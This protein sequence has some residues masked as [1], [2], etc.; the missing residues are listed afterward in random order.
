[1]KYFI[2][3][4]FHEYMKQPK[5]LGI[6]PIGKV[7]PTV[8][9]ISLALVSE[10]GSKE[11]YAETNWYNKR[12]ARKNAFLNKNVIPNLLGGE[13]IKSKKEI[14]EGILD[15]IKND[16]NPELV[17]WW[18]AYDWW[19]LC[20]EIFGTMINTM[21]KTNFWYYTDF[22]SLLNNTV[23]WTKKEIIKYSPELTTIKH[24]ALVDARWLRKTYIL[25]KEKIKTQLTTHL[26]LEA[27]DSLCS[28]IEHVF[29]RCIKNKD[30]TY[31]I[32]K[33]SATKWLTRSKT[34]FNNLNT[35]E[36]RTPINE[37]NKYLTVFKNYFQLLK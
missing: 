24:N 37:S 27:H 7:I 12:A 11:F 34:K 25:S 28:L 20:M 23:G 32:S 19:T 33:E 16:K 14:Q 31:T 17:G 30:G 18:S 13:H 1:M 10:D 21:K 22:K 36:L 15:L 35:T 6:I 29:N 3:C 5:L 9:L 4:E 2:D 26:K 8:E